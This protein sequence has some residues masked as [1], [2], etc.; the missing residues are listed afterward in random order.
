M[1]I[2]L[3]PIALDT[4]SADQQGLLVLSEGRLIGVLVRLEDPVHE[5]ALVGSW[6]LECA[7]GKLRGACN[8]VFENLQS[9]LS[10]VETRLVPVIACILLAFT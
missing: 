4:N 7:I 2:A 1:S 9:A 5:E 8:P 10:W 6:Y 3:Q